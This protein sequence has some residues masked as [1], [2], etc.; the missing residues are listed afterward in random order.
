MISYDSLIS[1]LVSAHHEKDAR[2]EALESALG[3]I[4]QQLD[5]Q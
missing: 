4:Q 3:G 1:V 5:A 2:I